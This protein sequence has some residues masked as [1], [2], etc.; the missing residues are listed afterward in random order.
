MCKETRAGVTTPLVPLTCIRN[1]KFH[2]LLFSTR[3][4]KEEM[5]WLQLTEKTGV[6]WAD[7]RQVL[8]LG[9]HN[10]LSYSQACIKFK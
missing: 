1:R 7:S 3:E 2:S 5:G 4:E 6:L 10:A 8:L 9:K